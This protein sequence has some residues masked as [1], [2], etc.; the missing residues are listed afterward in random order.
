M[1]EG[2]G[3][4]KERGERR[5]EAV[6]ASWRRGRKKGGRDG[7]E[8]VAGRKEGKEGEDGLGM[9]MEASY[10]VG[11]GRDE[12][13]K[14][15]REKLSLPKTRRSKARRKSKDMGKKKKGWWKGKRR[16]KEDFGRGNGKKQPLSCCY[17]RKIT[18]GDRDANDFFLCNSLSSEDDSSCRNAEKSHS[19]SQGQERV[20]LHVRTVHWQIGLLKKN[21][22][23]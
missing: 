18:E 4:R 14:E 19:I 13:R 11:G 8:G 17:R 2:E 10:A 5:E 7:G 22:R 9:E 23:C 1:E 16:G 6:E 20:F 21:Q 12:R 15:E 3:G